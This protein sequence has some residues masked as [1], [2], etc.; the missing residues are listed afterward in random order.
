M[1]LNIKQ[2]YIDRE[3]LSAGNKYGLNFRRVENPTRIG[4]YGEIYTCDYYKFDV[5]VLKKSDKALY[6]SI[7]TT[8]GGAWRCW[9]PKSQ[10]KEFSEEK[11]EKTSKEEALDILARLRKG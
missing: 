11:K 9:V 3:Q 10:I 2:W 5:E 6:L 1:I 7:P 8:N 4:E